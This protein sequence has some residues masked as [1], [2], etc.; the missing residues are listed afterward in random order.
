MKKAA[1]SSLD[2]SGRR[3][4]VRADFNV[5][6]GPGGVVTDDLRI[7]ATLPTI[8]QILDRGGSVVA[9]SHMGRPK[10][11]PDPKASLL[12]CAAV[13]SSLLGARVEL[14]PGCS[15][16]ETTGMASALRPGE[17]LLLENLRFDPGEE[18]NDP[19][20]AGR[21]AALAD[22]YVNDAFGAAHRAHASVAAICSRFDRPSAGLLM[23]REIDYLG[24]LLESPPKPYVAI[25]GG[26]KVTG[27]IELIESLLCHV[28]RILIGGAMAYTFLKAR[29]VP[30]GSS[31]VEEEKLELARSL[32]CKAAEAGVELLFPSD[33]VLGEP[34]GDVPLGVSAGEQ[35]EAGKVGF[36]I[37]PRTATAFGSAI[38]EART[39]LW[40]GPMGRFEVRGF[41]TGTR[42]IASA[43]SEATGRGAL[44]VVGGGD[45]AA[46]VRA[47][48]ME[49]GFSHISTGGGASLEMLSGR[50]LPGVAALADEA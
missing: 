17:V 15:G 48:Q 42:R 32:E 28:D 23:Q 6:L 47:F 18:S 37:G 8:R 29:G 38:S 9:A 46:A 11:K 19:A 36:D 5:P 1:V 33:H 10:G 25:L 20:F 45:S 26:A 22:L 44:T 3:V 14:A 34:G 39:I 13:L 35:V 49:A 27:K 43:I 24:R 41:A 2:V 30:V 50:T 7:R 21:L 12:P 40:N 16:P 31:L 4:F